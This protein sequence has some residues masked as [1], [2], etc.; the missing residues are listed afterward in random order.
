MPLTGDPRTLAHP[1][2]AD[3]HV[4]GPDRFPAA[5]GHALPPPEQPARRDAVLAGHDRGD[6]PRVSPTSSPSLRP[7]ADRACVAELARLGLSPPP[8][9]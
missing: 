9:R 7:A 4:V 3:H 8:P 5:L 1:G 2:S 6:E